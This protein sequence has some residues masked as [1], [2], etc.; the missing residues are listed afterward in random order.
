MKVKVLK[1]FVSLTG[2]YFAG[3]EVN[4]DDVKDFI[5]AGF[6]KPLDKNVDTEPVV[7]SPKVAEE[8]SQPVAAEEVPVQ[9]AEVPK[10]K[11]R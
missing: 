5:E 3:S 1:S 10:K 2:S 8:V 9:E 4:I 6:V 11:K 7:E